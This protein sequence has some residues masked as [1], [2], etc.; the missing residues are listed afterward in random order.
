MANE[1]IEKTIGVNSSNNKVTTSQEDMAK[2]YENMLNNVASMIKDEGPVIST[3]I[4]FQMGLTGD[5]I[6]FDSSSTNPKKNLI[7]NLSFKKSC[8]GVTNDFTLTVQYDPFNYGQE[9]VDVIEKLDEYVAKAMSVDFK[10]DLTALR[11]TIQYG[12]SSMSD[13]N[14]TSPLYTFYLT[15]ANTTVKFESGI[16]T[17]EFKG[18]SVLA[19]D[20]DNVTKFEAITEEV[21]MLAVVEATL[22][23]WYGTAEFKP[24]HLADIEIFKDVEPYPNNFNYKIDIPDEDFKD[25]V[26][27]TV[28]ATNGMTPFVY[29]QHILD[30]HFLS[31][32]EVD[33]GLYD[34]LTKLTYWQRPRYIM[35][36]DDA[37]AT[38]RVTHIIPQYTD[39]NK[40]KLQKSKYQ[41]N[42]PFYWGT[43]N[44]NIVTGWQPQV[45]T[46]LYLIRRARVQRANAML[47][48]VENTDDNS[49]I[50]DFMKQIPESTTGQNTDERMKAFQKQLIDISDNLNEMYDAQLQILGIPADPP[51]G[52]E[53]RIKPVILQ[54]VSRTAGVYI[55][56]GCQDEITTNGLYLTTLQVFR[57]RA[58]DDE[59]IDVEAEAEANKKAQESDAKQKAEEYNAGGGGYSSGGGRRWFFWRSAA[60]MVAGGRRWWF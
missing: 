5:V 25:S 7:A 38:I 24:S 45:Q 10:T 57:V 60:E 26:K 15:D 11:G 51:L 43:Q 41:I 35:Y 2:Q 18:T 9:A 55:I 46:M 22:Y 48:S 39:E 50:E 3:W 21:P 14:L 23:K 1:Y 42:F 37:N 13:L 47:G 36:V 58:L 16:S 28:A 52:A 53:I 31:Q 19:A 32:S 54:T 44:K 29:C 40:E 8:A 6:T 12:Y 4:R 56:T 33:S 34:D 17:Y 49:V 59:T 30:E 27:I 20:C